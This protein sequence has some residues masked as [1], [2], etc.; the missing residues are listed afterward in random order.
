MWCDKEI[1]HQQNSLR[2]LRRKIKLILACKLHRLQEAE[3][4]CVYEC[5]LVSNFSEKGSYKV[6]QNIH[7]TQNLSQSQ[8]A[9]EDLQKPTKLV[10]SFAE[11]SDLTADSLSPNFCQRLSFLKMF[12]MQ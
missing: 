9:S 11:M 10:N 2:S 8:T 12:T 1:K 7:L 3:D 4:I 6:Y 5:K